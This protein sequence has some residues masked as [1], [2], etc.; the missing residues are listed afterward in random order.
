MTPIWKD[1]T[2]PFRPSSLIDDAVNE[3]VPRG[4]RRSSRRQTAVYRR[5]AS[6]Q[7]TRLPCHSHAATLS[8]D[9][10]LRERKCKNA[11]LEN[12][13]KMRGHC[14]GDGRNGVRVPVM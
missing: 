8:L 9:R 5:R 4:R 2:I 6:D 13:L 7:S 3:N 14:I 11:A 10:R 12:Q 1:N